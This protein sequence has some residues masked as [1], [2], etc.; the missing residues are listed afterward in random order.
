MRLA[1]RNLSHDRIR[2]L[3]TVVGIAFAVFLMVFQGSLLTGFIR[4]AS[5]GIDL[6][7]GDIWICARG[8]DC[9]EF[10][11]PL[12]NRF[13]DLAMGVPGVGRVYRMVVGFTVLQK[14][15]G[16]QQMV[17]L[18]GAED[19]VGPAFPIPHQN[20]GQNQTGS[21][22]MTEALLIDQS[23]TAAL[24]ISATPVHTELAFQRART[25]GTID[26]FASFFGTPYVFSGYPDA[27]RYLGMTPEQ[28]FFLIARVAPGYDVQSV[29]KRLQAELPEAD[30]WTR[31]EFSRR[32]RIFWILKT[33]AGGALLTAAL[34]G[35]LVGLVVVSQNIYA[36]TM[37]N[38]EE[39]ATLKAIGA[40]RRYIQRIVLSQGLFSGVVGSSLGLAATFPL[41]NAVRGGI[42]WVYTPWWLPVGMIGVGLAMCALA[43]VISVRKAVTV[44][45]GKVFRA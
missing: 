37:E 15:A 32:A 42:P 40:S 26:N 7:D 45:P 19:G 22:V 35:F 21:A 5:K 12:P 3:V 6:T 16:Y 20:Q 34:L 44:D 4:T 14:P 39:F 13:R 23:N 38:I 18:V 2:F 29:K 10:A 9:F 36:T 30:V 27:I 11:T 25:V 41:V 1:W 8:V 43:S 24:G 28:T 33:G 31:H 17:L